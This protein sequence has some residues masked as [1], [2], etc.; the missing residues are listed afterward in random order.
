MFLEWIETH[1]K[2]G[3]VKELN[4]RLRL[5]KYGDECWTELTGKSVDALWSE[6]VSQETA[7]G[8][9]VDP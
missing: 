5:G 2:K 3:V 4:A 6:F 9:K 1:H 7:S 8:N